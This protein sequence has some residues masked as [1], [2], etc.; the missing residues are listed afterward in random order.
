MP[1]VARGI[2]ERPGFPG[3]LRAL[4][5]VEGIE[6]HPGFPGV[7]RA[8]AGAGGIEARPGFAGPRRALGG[9]GGHVGAPHDNGLAS[10]S[11]RSRSTARSTVSAMRTRR[12][13]ARTPSAAGSMPR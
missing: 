6:E 8:L 5:D 12:S 13:P 2:E 7:L 3:V 1:I 4:A 9:V 11:N 10:D